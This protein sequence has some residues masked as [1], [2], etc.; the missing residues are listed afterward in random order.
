ML[1]QR[2]RRHGA[3]HPRQT[4]S[5]LTVEVSAHLI[6][7][8]PLQHVHNVLGPRTQM[9]A[10]P[11]T[12]NAGEKKTDLDPTYYYLIGFSKFVPGLFTDD[13]SGRTLSSV[14]ALSLSFSVSSTGTRSASTSD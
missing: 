14:L 7:L 5:L 3:P 9:T 4:Q 10:T 8:V 1:T 2:G 12:V 13:K 11:I 6:A